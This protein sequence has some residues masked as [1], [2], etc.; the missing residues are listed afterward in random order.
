MTKE[1]LLSE[2][3]RSRLALSRDFGAVKNELNVVSKVERFF[4]KRPLV[5]LGGAAALGWV[6]AGPRTKTKIVKVGAGKEKT[7]SLAKREAS[8]PAGLVG[9]LLAIFKIAAPILK[10]AFSAY[11]A[12]RFADMASHLGK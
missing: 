9:I 11:A 8:R 2:I 6:I 12:K 5:W 3:D 1:E 7:K 4:Q 10:P